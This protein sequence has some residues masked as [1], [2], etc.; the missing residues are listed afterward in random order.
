MTAFTSRW[1]DW[2]PSHSTEGRGDGG[3]SSVHGTAPRT[4]ETPRKRTDKTDNLVSEGAKGQ[5]VRFVSATPRRFQPEIGRDADRVGRRLEVGERH[6]G[7]LGDQ[8]VGDG[9]AHAA[10]AGAGDQRGLAGE[11]HQLA[12]GRT[13]FI[14][15]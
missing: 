11:P 3:N 5:I 7:A 12:R 4:P 2:K 9:E 6:V 14:T 8:A 1:A 13:P 10:A 15:A